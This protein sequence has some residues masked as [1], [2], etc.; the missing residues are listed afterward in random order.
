[1]QEQNKSFVGIYYVSFG[2]DR[3]NCKNGLAI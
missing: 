2:G 3:L 1:M